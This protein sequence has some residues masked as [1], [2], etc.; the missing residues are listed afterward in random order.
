MILSLRFGIQPQD[1]RPGD[2]V[3]SGAD[4]DGSPGDKDSKVS[5]LVPKLLIYPERVLAE[6]DKGPRAPP[7]W[8]VLPKEFLPS[9]AS[10]IKRPRLSQVESSLSPG[11]E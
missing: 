8:V 4:S 7:P 10:G 11:T 5:S 9:G 2:D 3:P 6:H 1:N